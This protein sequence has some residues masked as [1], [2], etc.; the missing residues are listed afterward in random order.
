[1]AILEAWQAVA[2]AS[3]ELELVLLWHNPCGQDRW[4]PGLPCGGVGA[5]AVLVSGLQLGESVDLLTCFGC[6]PHA[7]LAL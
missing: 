5:E 2:V 3:M 4:G 1:M 6:S 7:P